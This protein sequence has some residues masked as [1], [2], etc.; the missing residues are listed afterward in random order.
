[1]RHVEDDG[2]MSV[3]DRVPLPTQLERIEADLEP[4]PTALTGRQLE[5]TEIEDVGRPSHVAQVSPA[6][7]E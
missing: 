5:L 7:L 2:G 4:Q 3:Q 1:M 6:A